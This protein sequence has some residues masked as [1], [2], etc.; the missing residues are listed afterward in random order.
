MARYLERSWI[1]P[2]IE[3]KKSAIAGW[4]TFAARPFLAGE[5]VFIFGGQVVTNAEIASGL[6]LPHS[7]VN[8]DDDLQIGH[9]ITDGVD[10][11]D[12]L[13]HS[14]QPNVWM[15]DE[16]T[17]VAMTDIAAGEEVA[18]DYAMYLADDWVPTWACNCQ[19][20]ACRGQVT[21]DDWK[22]PAL[23]ERYRS[24]FSPFIERKIEHLRRARQGG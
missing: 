22:L 18:I 5:V 21:R 2:R 7:Y 23:Q 13:N 10:I 3:R 12:Y 1:D 20:P 17:V 9:L 24:H 19:T 4:G 11:D 16:V 6:V 15:R 8:I 14:C